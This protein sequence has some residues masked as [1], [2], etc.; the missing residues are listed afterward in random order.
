M[1]DPTWVFSIGDY[2]E[3]CHVINDL[4][5]DVKVHV[6]HAVENISSLAV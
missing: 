4:G 3:R 2:A 1:W 5:D 6:D